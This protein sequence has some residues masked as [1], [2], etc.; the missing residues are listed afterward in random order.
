MWDSLLGSLSLLDLSGYL[1]IAAIVVLTII[2]LGVIF[3]VRTRYALIGRELPPHSDPT[4]GFRNRVLQR[5]VRDTQDAYRTHRGNINIQAIIEANFTRGL[6]TALVGER[7]VKALTGLLII[8]GL[9][10]TFY[11]LTLSIGKLVTLVSGDMSEA[12]E[13]TQSLTKGLTEALAGMSVAFSTSLFGILAAIVMT[14]FGIFFNL[15]DRRT[16]L[17]VEI[18]AYLDNQLLP[19]MKDSYGAKGQIGE[20]SDPVRGDDVGID[21]G[22][23]NVVVHFGQSVVRLEHVVTRF[24]ETFDKFSENTRDF[25]EFNAHLKDNI[26]R[27]SLS[28][29][30]LNNALIGNMVGLKKPVEE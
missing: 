11:G 14:L 19:G 8:L 3:S 12:G 24:E 20:G 5:I 30:D 18:E 25:G 1:I 26:Q 7:F 16:A 9:V 15:A 28:F 27:M 4:T 13:I 2:G 23:G 29:S 21:A 22:L 10:G 17:M 6:R